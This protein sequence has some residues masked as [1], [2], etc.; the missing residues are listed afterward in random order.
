MNDIMKHRL[1]VSQNILK[2]FD[3]DIEKARYGIYE[4]NAEN[5]RLGRVG[6]K[7][8]SKKNDLKTDRRGNY[9]GDGSFH[10]DYNVTDFSKKYPQIKSEVNESDT[11]ESVYVTYRNTDNNKKVTLRFSDHENNAVK[12]G[13]QLDGRW[14]SNDEILY[15]LG[16]KEREFI[17]DKYLSVP[18]RQ[19][20]KKEM[21]N[22]EEAP[23][24]IQEIYALGKDA[25]L[26]EYKGKLAKNSNY[27]IEGDKIT[28][29]EIVRRDPLLGYTY[30]TGKYIYRDIE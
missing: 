30:R 17:P 29:H 23:L 15:H 6:Q 1:N 3:T 14:T 28:E 24:T 11:T 26:S 12:W 25:D 13:D 21:K 20:K 4:D 7:Y 16:L 2:S 10:V 5:R 18:Y 27:L 9:I 8:G 22:Y 19:I